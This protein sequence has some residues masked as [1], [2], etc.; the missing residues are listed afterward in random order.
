MKDITVG[1][2]L[3]SILSP[4]FD[5]DIFVIDLGLDNEYLDNLL[6]PSAKKQGP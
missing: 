5:V 6:K 3:I 1:V 4:N 2:S